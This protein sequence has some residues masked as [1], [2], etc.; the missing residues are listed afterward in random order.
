[1]LN[2]NDK[3]D[4]LTEQQLK[5]VIKWTL[6][7][8]YRTVHEYQGLNEHVKGWCSMLDEAIKYQID[9]QYNSTVNEEE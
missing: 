5:A 1:M 2:I 6:S 3:L 9:K 8:L 4:S 7:D